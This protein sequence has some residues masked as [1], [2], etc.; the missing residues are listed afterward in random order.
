M[1]LFCTP[2]LLRPGANASLCPPPLVMLL[3]TIDPYDLNGQHYTCPWN[4]AD[5]QNNA[6][7]FWLSLVHSRK[8]EGLPSYATVKPSSPFPSPPSPSH[9][10]YPFASFPSLPFLP[11]P[12]PNPFL[13]LPS[14]LQR[15]EGL[16]VRAEP[17]RQTHFCAIHSAK[18]ANLLKVSPTCTGRPYN[19]NSC[20]L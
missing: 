6:N 20:E 18:F 8:G 10:P 9:P 11:L 12:I 16:G 3:V 5:M 15:L 1:G 2:R 7:Q 19:I 13:P 17:G 14:L 4:T